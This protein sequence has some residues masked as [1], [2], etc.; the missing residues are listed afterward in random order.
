MPRKKVNYGLVDSLPDPKDYHFG[1]LEK[2]V[3][4]KNGDWTPFLPE[5]EKQVGTYQDTWAC[6]TFSALNCLE[7]IFKRRYNFEVNFSDRFTAK[8]SGTIPGKGNTLK[9]VADSIRNDGFLLEEDYYWDRKS[10][11]KY[12]QRIPDYYGNIQYPHTPL[13]GRANIIRDS[14]EVSYEWVGWNGLSR[15]QLSEAL[16]YGPLQVT[17]MAWKAPKNGVYDYTDQNI[18]HAVTLLRVNKDGSLVIFDS[19]DDSIKVLSKRFYIGH[20]MQFSLDIRSLNPVTFANL[21]LTNHGRLPKLRE[22]SEYLR[23]GFLPFI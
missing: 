15:E 20:A 8:M 21:Y 11:E 7:I 3:L 2:K 22:Y 14:Y 23:T 4:E 10:K 18:N 12:Y 13:K 9:R 17:V 6:V 1:S 16:I 19:Y 5:F